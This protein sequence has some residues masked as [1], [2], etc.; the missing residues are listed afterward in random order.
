V[1]THHS[2][3][4]LAKP[5]AIVARAQEVG[6]EVLAVTD[7]DTWRGAVDARAAAEAAG[8]KVTVVLGTEVRTDQGDMVGLFVTSDLKER[9]ALAFCDAVHE[10][11]GIVVLP[12]PYKWHRLDDEL[13]AKV[14]VV[15]VHNARCSR[16]ENQ[17]AADLALERNLAALVGPDA[18][19]VKELLLARNEFDGEIP[20]DED[21]MKHALLHAPRRFFTNPA[22]IWNEWLSQGVK[23]TRRPSPLL[24]WGL[25]RGAV[26][27]LVKPDAYRQA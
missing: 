27:R 15:E 2:P 22:G 3:D 16:I 8:G 14:D 19:R 1:H 21:A 4:S 9:K 24:A 13:L 25:L 17:K 26:R 18:H 5:E 7:H 20:A 23:F 11:G 12:H 6:V 10:Q